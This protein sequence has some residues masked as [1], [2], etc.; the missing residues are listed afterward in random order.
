MHREMIAL[1]ILRPL[2]PELCFVGETTSRDLRILHCQRIVSLVENHFR[3]QLPGDYTT[4]F[5][6]GLFH[7]CLTLIPSLSDP[8]SSDLFTRAANLLHRT[9]VDLPGMRQILRGVQAV[10]WG[11]RKSLPQG[12]IASFEN[13]KPPSNSVEVK[14]EWGFP[15]TEYIQSEPGV[16]VRDLHGVQGSLGRMIEMW[17]GGS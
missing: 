16:A 4:F 15:Q 3:E 11:M 2:N 13:L 7:V 12:A 1:F 8:V 9:V 5:L 10:V 6:A 14:A 17:E